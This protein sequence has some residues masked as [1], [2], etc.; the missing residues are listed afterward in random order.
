MV[1][2]TN[3]HFHESAYSEFHR[4]L[5]S[6]LRGKQRRDLR[7]QTGC[8]WKKL[9]SHYFKS[10]ETENQI[11]LMP[12]SIAVLLILNYAIFSLALADFSKIIE[13]D[14]DDADAYIIRGDAYLGKGDFEFCHEKT[15]RRQ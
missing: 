15:I 11:F 9:L 3:Q 7:R 8:V 4:G 13:L 10:F 6:Q 2:I 5:T 14:P 12:L 1:F